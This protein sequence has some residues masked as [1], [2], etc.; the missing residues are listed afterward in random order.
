[1]DAAIA[2]CR[3]RTPVHIASTEN[4]R[5]TM[6]FVKGQPWSAYNWYKGDNQSLIEINTDWPIA[7]RSR[8]RARLP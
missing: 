7:D 6:A 2:E 5:F 8:D 1:M 4:E 3:R